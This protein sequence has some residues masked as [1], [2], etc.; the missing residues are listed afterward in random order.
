MLFSEPGDVSDISVNSGALSDAVIAACKE[1]FDA[2]H[3][4]AM[5]KTVSALMQ[6]PTHNPASSREEAWSEFIPAQHIIDALQSA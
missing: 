3:T 1:A 6:D 5:D 4:A 2:G